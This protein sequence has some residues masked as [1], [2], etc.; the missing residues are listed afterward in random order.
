VTLQNYCYSKFNI[1]EITNNLT[2]GVVFLT[3]AM[4]SQLICENTTISILGVYYSNWTLT[5]DTVINGNQN[6]EGRN[7]DLAGHKLEVKGDFIQP[8]GVVNINK[9][10]LEVSGNYRMQDHNSCK[11]HVY[12]FE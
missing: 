5:G 3:K 6:L 10:R 11:R 8:S 1:L 12:I 2:S 7:L 4:V 9:G